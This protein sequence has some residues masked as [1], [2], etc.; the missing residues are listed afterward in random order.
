[1]WET[2]NN[3][4]TYVLNVNGNRMYVYVHGWNTN[5]YTALTESQCQIV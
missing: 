2:N 5:H 4:R 1:M 3:H